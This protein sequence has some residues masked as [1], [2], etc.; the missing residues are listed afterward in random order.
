M[1]CVIDDGPH[2]GEIIQQGY[3]LPEGRDSVRKEK[4][5]ARL[6]HVCAALDMVKDDG[7]PTVEA[8]IGRKLTVDVEIFQ[9]PDGTT[10]TPRN[11]LGWT[12]ERP[13]RNWDARMAE[14]TTARLEEEYNKQFA[15]AERLM[16]EA[17][18]AAV[19]ARLVRER[20]AKLRSVAA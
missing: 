10:G 1:G 2:T 5:L 20:L 11:I 8:A 7:V 15:D 19:R 16:N 14:M 13:W 9:V 12:N 3:G 4:L 18:E 17:D 6:R